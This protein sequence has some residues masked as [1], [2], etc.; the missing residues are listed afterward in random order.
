MK[1]SFYSISLFDK[2][3]YNTMIDFLIHYMG[4]GNYMKIIKN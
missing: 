1:L 4:E 2:R 3:T